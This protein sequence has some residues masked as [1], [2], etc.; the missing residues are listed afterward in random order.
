MTTYIV[1]LAVLK[2]L[3]TEIWPRRCGAAAVD[4]RQL[5]E[6]RSELRCTS[7]QRQWRT[8]V[9]WRLSVSCRGMTL[10]RKAAPFFGVHPK[11]KQVDQ[12]ARPQPRLF[13]L[14]AR[15]KA[16]RAHAHARL[17]SFGNAAAKVYVR[18]VE[19]RFFAVNRARK[20]HAFSAHAAV[21]PAQKERRKRVA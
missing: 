20:A 9:C 4:R 17:F 1:I 6:P 18:R 5:S 21:R 8:G 19:P 2:D 7:R 14:A 15:N 16:S 13:T 3:A 10:L 12:D 11:G